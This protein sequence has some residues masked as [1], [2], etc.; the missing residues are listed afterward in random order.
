MRFKETPTERL[1]K[2]INEQIKLKKEQK[3][4]R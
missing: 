1:I 4:Q 2:L 3:K